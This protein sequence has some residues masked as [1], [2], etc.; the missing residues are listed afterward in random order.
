MHCRKNQQSNDF[1]D[2]DLQNLLC[3]PYKAPFFAATSACNAQRHSEAMMAVG[4]FGEFDGPK[5]N[6]HFEQWSSIRL[7]LISLCKIAV[8]TFLL[9]VLGDLSKVPATGAMRKA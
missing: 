4:A 6:A 3:V 2:K 8:R 9:A 5:Y 1:V 7:F